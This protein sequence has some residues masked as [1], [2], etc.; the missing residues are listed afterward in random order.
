MIVGYNQ[1]AWA[2]DF[3]FLLACPLLAHRWSHQQ[4]GCWSASDPEPTFEPI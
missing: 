4:L 3:Q 1:A 2:W